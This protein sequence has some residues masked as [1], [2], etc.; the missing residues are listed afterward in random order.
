[1]ANTYKEGLGVETF[2]NALDCMGMGWEACSNKKG[3]KLI[4]SGLGV[5]I[6]A[7][8][9]TIGGKLAEAIAGSKGPTAN[10]YN[11]SN[12]ADKAISKADLEHP[13]VQSRINVQNGNAREGWEHVVK[14]HFSGKENASQF[15]LSQTE[16]KSILQSS[17]V[18][19]IP[20]SNTHKSINKATGQQET[21]CERV[22]IFDKNIGIDEFSGGN[23]TNTMTILTDKKGNL[24]TATPGRM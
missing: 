18:A 2:N 13:I 3:W 10:G 23:P 12:G 17:D 22:I 21:L 6:I 15:T 19:K 4:E 14:R 5:L 7:G 16:V 8:G 9:Q 20:I 11:I 24:I 1:M